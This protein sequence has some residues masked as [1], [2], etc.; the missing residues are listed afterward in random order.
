M[1]RAKVWTPER[2]DS[3][4]GMA[5]DGLTMPEAAAR[6]G[7]SRGNVAYMARAFGVRFNGR[8]K[9][10]QYT[11]ADRGAVARMADE[12]MSA[13]E[14]AAALGRIVPSVASFVRRES[15]RLHGKRGRKPKG[16]AS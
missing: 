8:R 11:E 9:R 16:G 1:S 2:V 5:A 4:R 3:L 10:P 7:T 15:I 6:L 12:G 14:I 13:K